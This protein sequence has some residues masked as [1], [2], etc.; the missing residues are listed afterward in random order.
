MKNRYI[1]GTGF[2]MSVSLFVGV[3]GAAQAIPSS[4]TEV[5][6]TARAELSAAS[7]DRALAAEFTTV[8]ELIMSVP[9]SVLL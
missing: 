5:S 7:A 4:A 2:L 8:L 6:T 9:D 1:I 3:G